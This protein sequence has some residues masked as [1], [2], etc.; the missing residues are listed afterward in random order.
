MYSLV[1]IGACHKQ[2]PS[3]TSPTLVNRVHAATRTFGIWT[4][5]EY[6]HSGVPLFWIGFASAVRDIDRCAGLLSTRIL[7]SISPLDVYF[8]YTGF[9]PIPPFSWLG[10][11]F[12]S[13]GT[14]EK[15]EFGDKKGALSLLS[16]GFSFLGLSRGNILGA[17]Y[18]LHSHGISR[19]LVT[20]F[21][22]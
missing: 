5:K 8:G 16:F 20:M 18:P 9:A 21:G 10:G 7:R 22:L 2:P 1:V 4:L 11:W 3:R 15:W 6:R 14:L 12:L 17:D 19:N 13:P